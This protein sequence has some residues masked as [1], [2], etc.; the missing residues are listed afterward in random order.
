MGNNH[1]K[2]IIFDLGNVL[3]DFD[4]YIAVSRVS[5]FTD[6]SPNQI[7]EIF[8]DSKLITLFEEGR[9]AP[10]DF[11][12]KVK[13][14]LKLKLDYETFLPIWNEI[15]FLTPKNE[16]VY[17]LAQRL[18]EHY[19]LALVS[20]INALHLDYIK[21]KFRVFEPFQS[22]I[23][24]C[25]V[26]ISK[27]DPLIYQKTLEALGSLPQNTFY[28]DDRQELVEGAVRLGIKGFV[29]KGIEQLHK[30]LVATGINL[31]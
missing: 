21:K 4:H 8:F 25:E 23:A 1:I 16:Q 6:K 14:M 24:S 11:F 20:N 19:P 13:E 5:R 27:P 10:Q 9:I 29:F 12:S 26:R 22:I 18:K 31:N 28:A 2:A 17:N 3:V 7:F 15:F 30:D